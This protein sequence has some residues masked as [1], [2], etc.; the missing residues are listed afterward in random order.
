MTVPIARDVSASICYPGNLRS[1][2][3]HVDDHVYPYPEPL[4]A[5]HESNATWEPFVA[6]SGGEK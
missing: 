6:I 3:A 4:A 2:A 1:R 5:V